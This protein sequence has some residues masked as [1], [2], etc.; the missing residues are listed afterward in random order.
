MLL[1]GPVATYRLGMGLD[2]CPSLSYA[3]LFAINELPSP[4]CYEPGFCPSAVIVS[5]LC[6]IAH[7]YSLVGHYS[8][9]LPTLC[10]PRLSSPDSSCWS[11]LP[12]S[13]ICTGPVQ[14]SLLAE[15]IISLLGGGYTPGL[16]TKI[17][18]CHLI[19]L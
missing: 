17:L 16:V 10:M 3:G 1:A 2:S 6:C 4:A 11:I 15:I 14:S 9:C 7:G 19:S 8:I 5:Q 18:A 12:L 13:I